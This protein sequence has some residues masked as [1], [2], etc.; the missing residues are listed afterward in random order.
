MWT[1]DQHYPLW[2]SV[3]YL[4]HALMNNIHNLPFELSKMHKMGTLSICEFWQ[5]AHFAHF[6]VFRSWIIYNIAI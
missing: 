1:G 6:W 3:L 5:G 2:D 4:D